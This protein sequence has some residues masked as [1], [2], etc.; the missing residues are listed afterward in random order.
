MRFST[1]RKRVLLAWVLLD[2][3]SDRRIVVFEK[4]QKILADIANLEARVNDRADKAALR[5]DRAYHDFEDRIS[6][7]EWDLQKQ[8]DGHALSVEAA[9][10]GLSNVGEQVAAASSNGSGESKQSAD[11][12]AA[13]TSGAVSAHPAENAHLAEV[14]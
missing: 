7:A 11:D 2:I 13:A 6:K 12:S 3:E 14:K 4:A 8:L 1:R 9:V 10:R 5:L